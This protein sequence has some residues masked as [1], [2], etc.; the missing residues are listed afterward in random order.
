[1]GDPDRLIAGSLDPVAWDEV[2]EVGHAMVDDMV[3]YLRDVRERPAWRTPSAASRAE[4]SSA[5]PRSGRPLSQVYGSFKRAILP[6]P[7]GNIHPRFW[8]WV[9]GGGTPVGMLAELLGGAMNCHVSGYDQAA[10]LVERQVIGWLRE[11]MGFPPDAG[12]LLVSGGTAANLIG[13][14]V[15]RNHALGRAVRR[16]GLGD[17]RGVVYA[18]DQVHGWL[19]RSCDLLGL[20]EGAVRKIGVGPDHRVE[21]GELRRAIERDVADGRTPLCVVGTAGTVS[22]GATD[23]LHGLADLAAEHGLWFHVDGAFGALARL[24]PRYRSLVDGLERADSLAFDLHKWGYM[25]YELG[26][27]LVRDADLQAETFDFA[28]SYLDKFRGGIAP[29]PT[30]FASKGVQLSRGFRALKAWMQL[31]VYGLDAIG[32]AIEQNIEQVAY[33][34]R[35]IDSAPRLERLGPSEMNVVCFRYRPPGLSGEAC[36]AFNAELLVRIQEEGVAVPSNARVD[37][38]FALRVAHTNH[39]TRPEDFDA[40]IDAVTR[41]AASMAADV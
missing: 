23:D 40:L 13:L 2:R 18:S 36:D 15:A 1:M 39:R 22:C 8:G 32:A 17:A 29:D 28:P 10:T 33:L 21:L 25:Q 20:G 35:L 26:A 14:T 3:D 6:Y 38:A 19:D 7:T 41:I 37:G 31:S 16:D 12:G 34:R 27:V 30:E 9:M 4:L 5:A 11:I 24:S